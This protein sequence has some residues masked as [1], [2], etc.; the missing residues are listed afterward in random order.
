MRLCW[1]DNHMMDSFSIVR[2]SMRKEQCLFVI[3]YLLLSK[4]RSQYFLFSGLKTRRGTVEIIIAKLH[5]VSRSIWLL[6]FSSDYMTTISFPSSEQQQYS[7]RLHNASPSFGFTYRCTVI[8]LRY[9]QFA[10]F[11]HAFICMNFLCLHLL[12][13]QGGFLFRTWKIFTWD[14][15][16]IMAELHT[17]HLLTQWMMNS[18]GFYISK[19]NSS[20]VTPVQTLWIGSEAK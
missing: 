20:P 19:W 5:I 7:P 8:S 9:Y 11:T 6:V 1:A 18:Q 15:W 16:K 14:S 2:C 17:M 12:L 13:I 4:F 3:L 10:L